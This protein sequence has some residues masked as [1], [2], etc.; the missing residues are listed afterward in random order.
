M[1]LCLWAPV[2]DSTR[3][4]QWWAPSHHHITRSVQHH[5][6]HSDMPGLQ[7]FLKERILKSTEST[8]CSGHNSMLNFHPA[9]V[10]RLLCKGKHSSLTCLFYLHADTF[11]CEIKI[12]G[13]HISDGIRNLYFPITQHL[14]KEPSIL[15]LQLAFHR[16]CGGSLVARIS[17]K[18]HGNRYIWM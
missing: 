2:P 5:V 9:C 18:S 10:A 3:L 13:F 15:D 12:K 4:K 1:V 16:L 7:Q 17:L 11:I 14:P 6:P 8:L